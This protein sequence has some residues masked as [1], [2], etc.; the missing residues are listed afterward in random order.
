MPS[1]ALIVLVGVS[2]SPTL[3]SVDPWLSMNEVV[4]ESESIVVEN[5]SVIPI[6]EWCPDKARL[7]F[8]SNTDKEVITNQVGF[9]FSA[10]KSADNRY[11]VILSKPH[12]VAEDYNCI[13]SRLLTSR[14][15]TT[16]TV[17]CLKYNGMTVKMGDDGELIFD[18]DIP[19]QKRLIEQALA[20]KEEKF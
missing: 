14:P 13:D 7:Q 11:W 6:P 4:W 5:L 10:S 1:I 2:L 15:M 16:V 8:A 20:M 18:S 12:C 17:Q 9:W 3:V 19:E